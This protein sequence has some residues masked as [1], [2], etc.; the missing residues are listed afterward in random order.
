MVYDVDSGQWAR[1]QIPPG[2]PPTTSQVQLCRWHSKV[3]TGRFSLNI[4]ELRSDTEK[5]LLEHCV[6]TKF[7]YLCN[8]SFHIKYAFW[9]KRRLTKRPDN[10]GPQKLV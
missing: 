5:A 3:R 9:L 1:V 6:P 7:G 10:S 2:Y 4:I 8:L